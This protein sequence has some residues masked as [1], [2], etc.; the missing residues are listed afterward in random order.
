MKT[1]CYNKNFMYYC[2]YGGKG[3]KICDEWKN[4]FSK[5]YKWAINNGYKEGLTID[6]INNDGNYEPLNCRWVTRKKQ[7]NNMN[8][9]IIIN[10][11]GKKQTISEWAD[12]LNLSRIALYY[13]IRRGWD[14]E[15]ALTTPLKK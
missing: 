2:N 8:K 9:N 5:F 1:R 3:I 6:R 12:E 10:Y 13:R 14:V 7:N 11:N 15:K 4:D